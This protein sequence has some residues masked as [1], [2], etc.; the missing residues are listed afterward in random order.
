MKLPT[1]SFFLILLVGGFLLSSPGAARGATPHFNQ[2]DYSEPWQ[3]TSYPTEAGLAQQRVFDIAFTPN[4]NVW[5]AV[6]DGLRRFD[7]F[8]WSLFGTNQGLPS[9]FIRAVCADQQGRLWV[10][11]DAGAGI[12]NERGQKYQAE[13]SP[14]GLANANVREIDQDPDGTLWFSCDEWPEPS[15]KPGGLTSFNPQSGE[16]KTE[17]Q[18]NGL[19]M[20]YII[21][22]FRDSGGRQ[23]ALTPHGWGQ[24]QAGRWGPPVNPGHEAEDCVLQMAEARD[25]TLFAQGE[26]TLLTLSDGLWQTHP[27]S[28][29]RLVCTTG[30]GELAAVECNSERGQ[31]WFSLW[32]GHRFVRASAVV[33][34]PIGVRLYHLREAPDGSLWCVGTGTVV[35][36]VFRAG[37]WT[38]Y[39]RLPPPQ[40]TDV[41][42]RVWFAD[43]SGIVI[44]TQGHFQ[45]LAPGRLRAW[46]ATGRALIWDQGRDQLTVT[47]LENPAQRTVVETGC[48]TINA[49]T[50][51]AG[52]GFWILGQDAAGNGV[53]AHHENG[54]TKIM[55]PPEFQ[56]WQPTS[57][58]ACSPTQALIVASRRSDNVYGVA[59]L[60]GDRVEWLPFAPNPPPLTYANI[61]IGAGRQWLYGYSGLYEQSATQADHWSA[62]KAFQDT[63]FGW[64]LA[65]ASELF[66]TFSGGRN[67]HAGCALYCSNCWSQVQGEFFH[68]VFGAD[69]KTLY[70]PSRGGVYLRRQPGTLD[71]EFLQIP[72]DTFVNIAV[73]DQSGALW[74]GCSEGTLH[75]QP[76]HAAPQTIATVATVELRPGVSLPVAFRGQERFEN[77]ANPAGFR[78]SWRIDEGDWSPFEMLPGPFLKIPVLRPGGHVLAV[79]ARDVDGN[80]D[81]NPAKAQFAILTEPWQSQPWFLPLMGLVVLL[82][83][84]LAWRHLAHT[85]QLA[86]TNAAL[87][88]E[89]AVRQQTQTEL[90]RMQ[91]ELE[92]RVIDRTDQLTR[93]NRQLRH[94]ITERQQAEEQKR[95]LME[96]LGQAQKM[97]AIGTLAGGIAHDFNNILAVIIPYC[98]IVS[99]ELPDR[100]DLQEHLREMLKAANRAKNL[101]QQ[102]LTFS[103]RQ[104]Q[105]QRQSCDLS[106]ILKEAMILLRFVLPSTIQMT[107]RILPTHRVLTDPTQIHQIVM[108]LCVNAQHAMEGRQGLLEIGLDEIL[109]DDTLCARHP[110]LQPGLFVRITVR[111]T[112]CGIP[113]ENLQRI[114]DPFFTTK[115]V[116]KGTGLG[117]AVVL[118]IVKSHNGTVLVQSKPGE[119]TEFQILLPAQREEADE[120]SPA[121]QPPLPANGEHIMIV[122]D[123]AGITQGIERLLVHAGYQVTAHTN[124]VAALNDFITHTADFQLILTDLTMPGMNGLELAAKIREIRPGLP[125]ILT[126]GFV[127]NTVTPVQRA[128]HPNIRRIVEKPLNPKE[129]TQFIAEVLR[130]VAASK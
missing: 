12:W 25:G 56:G 106:S 42:G 105:M 59:R 119:G 44:Y 126:T 4:G 1:V 116:G 91:G 68:P 101:V 16:W 113:P 129:I 2:P 33:S 57:A 94:E 121:R 60:T 95:Q 118:G 27:D 54:R 86:V 18:T 96:Q 47:D 67:G 114:F 39:R 87:R 52:S 122:D 64:S 107:Q 78:Y 7:G 77:A 46:S 49:I 80:V 36:W 20:D 61:L 43:K 53:V 88:R 40:G 51:D 109:A 23:F 15:A 100:P 110:D 108:N 98:H 73:P 11:S 70:L 14:T 125:L 79:R 17:H 26:H 69:Q 21:G 35:R 97:E 58:A 3:V 81:L 92:Q 90:V 123:E 24:R 48:A 120:K 71:F 128:A 5:L 22:Y 75:Y 19:P 41:Q 34:C 104:P 10:G 32:D 76:G 65:S 115:E 99:E 8:S 112:G 31:L 82:L 85:R 102:I 72:I 117:L 55:T 83:I 93:S 38:L 103:R 62:V 63:G 37:K 124:P 84:W 66:L 6:D 50:A 111:D 45:E 130:E 13:G 28:Q 29:T 127:G 9:S 89:I 74:V 30:S